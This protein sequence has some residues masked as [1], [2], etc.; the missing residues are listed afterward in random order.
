M[1]LFVGLLLSSS[2]S[3]FYI[4]IFYNILNIYHSPL[5]L[6]KAATFLYESDLDTLVDGMIVK[7]NFENNTLKFYQVFLP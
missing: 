3:V 1:Y 7:R 5:S 6:A 4:R 2:N